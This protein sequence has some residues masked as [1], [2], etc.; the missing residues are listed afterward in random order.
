MPAAGVEIWLIE[1]K[2][3]SKYHGRVE[4]RAGLIRIGVMRNGI[5]IA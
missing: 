1:R 4:I 2:R 3:L 5:G